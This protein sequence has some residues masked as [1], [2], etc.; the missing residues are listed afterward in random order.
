MSLKRAFSYCLWESFWFPLEEDFSKTAKA[1]AKSLA[2][3]HTACVTLLREGFFLFFVVSV[4]CTAVLCFLH[5][6]ILSVSASNYTI[7][8]VTF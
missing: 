4:N 7:H 8:C 1:K 3:H 2:S 5:G 6:D